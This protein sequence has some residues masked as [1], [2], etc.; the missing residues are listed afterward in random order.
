MK[1][2]ALP[3]LTAAA[4]AVALFAA[5]ASQAATLP[6]DCSYSHFPVLLCAEELADQATTLPDS[7]TVPHPPLLLCVEDI[8]GVHPIGEARS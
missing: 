5:P 8:V 1:T 3:A 4:F 2:L 7:C 6:P